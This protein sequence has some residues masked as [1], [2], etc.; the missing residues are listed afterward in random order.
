MKLNRITANLTGGRVR[1]ATL[2]GRPFLVAPITMIVPG[3]LNGSMG[4]LLYT[5]N[6]LKKASVFNGVPLTLGHPTNPD[7]SSISARSPGVID[8]IGIGTVMNSRFYNGKLIAEGWFDVN[9]LKRI[10]PEVLE[11][12][13]NGVKIECST[14]VITHRK[15]APSGATY[16]GQRYLEEVVGMD[17]DHLAILTDTRGAC[18]IEDGCGV[19]ANGSGRCHCADCKPKMPAL[20]DLKAV[21]NRRG[22]HVYNRK[23]GLL[24]PPSMNWSNDPEDDEDA[25]EDGSIFDSNLLI[26]PVINWRTDVK[27]RKPARTERRGWTV[28]LPVM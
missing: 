8:R 11:A 15:R 24:L 2:Q 7:G 4:P 25:L 19:L 14:G 1:H 9:R 28:P 20:A 18:S 12:L 26:A 22:V 10:A 3:V 16:N 13:E 6:V 21:A 27:K 23:E 17:G 5:A